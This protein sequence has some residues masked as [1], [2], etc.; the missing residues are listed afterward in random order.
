M[1]ISPVIATLVVAISLVQTSLPAQSQV[2]APT[3][4][5]SS[6]AAQQLLGKHKFAL[7][8][9]SWDRWAEFGDLHAID[10]QGTIF[11]KGRQAKGDDYIEIDGRVLNI[12]AYEFTF[13]GRIVTRVSHKHQG[14]PCERN[15]TMLFKITGT[16]KYW[17]LQEMQSPCDTTTDY[18]DIFLRR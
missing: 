2:F 4:I 14:Q 5:D 13:Q 18:V 1:Q 11:I 10:R 3:V 17:R 9:I 8:W 12:K 16:R 6:F 15:G 7:Q